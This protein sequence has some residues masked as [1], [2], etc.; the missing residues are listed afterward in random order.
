MATWKAVERRIAEFLGG[1]R[2]PV[3]GRQRGNAPDVA[4]PDFAIE[5][6]HRE[7]MPFWLKDAMDQAVKSRRGDQLPVVILHEKNQRVENCYVM[8]Q[9]K[10][11]M[12]IEDELRRNKST[13]D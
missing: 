5:V 12:G 10:D 8:I 11:L 2:V 13:D 9:L 1:E 3:T 7:R 6:K 4:H